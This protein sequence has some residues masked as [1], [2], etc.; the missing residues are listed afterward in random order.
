MG[1]GGGGETHSEAVNTVTVAVCQMTK[2][3][4]V[5]VSPF[6]RFL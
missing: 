6:H 4:T 1:R 2:V 3:S 5:S